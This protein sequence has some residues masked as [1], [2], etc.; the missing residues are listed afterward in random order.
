MADN[1]RESHYSAM[2]LRALK[3]PFKSRVRH[4]FCKALQSFNLPAARELFKPSTDSANLLVEIE[5][6][7]F[8][9]FVIFIS[10]AFVLCFAKCS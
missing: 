2:S 9:F 4:S 3:E 10:K 5:K 8:S 7:Q 6:K 1:N